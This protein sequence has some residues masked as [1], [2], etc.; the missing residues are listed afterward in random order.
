MIVIAALR[1]AFGESPTAVVSGVNAGVNLGRAILHSGT[2]GAA[3][4]AHNLGIHGL[5]VSMQTG[6]DWTVA[7][8]L[9]VEVLEEML[10]TGEPL[11]ANV[12]V[13][14][15]ALPHT[16]RIR[17]KLAKFGAVT[18][19]LDGEVLDFQMTI[20]PEAFDEPGTD[21]AAVREGHV[22]ITW[23]TGFGGLADAGATFTLGKV[24]SD[25]T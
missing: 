13:P 22:S 25:S 15:A 10:Q 23:L 18:A 20:D 21:G 7:A 2:V 17:T 11:L 3:L 4:T 9:G 1:G 24:R 14:A 16:P 8:G 19:A 6:G 5:A 12:N